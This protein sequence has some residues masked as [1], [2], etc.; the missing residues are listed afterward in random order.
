MGRPPGRLSFGV[1]RHAGAQALADVK[2]QALDQGQ[3]PRIE[4]PIECP[5]EA[6][7]TGPSSPFV[8]L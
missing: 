4:E 5:G 6:H 8:S 2:F 1:D 7:R 3:I